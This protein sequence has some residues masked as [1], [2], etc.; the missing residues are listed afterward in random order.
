MNSPRGVVVSHKPKCMRVLTVMYASRS[1]NIYLQGN[2]HGKIRTKAK[3]KRALQTG[4]TGKDTYR[5]MS[6]VQFR[7][8]NIN[9]QRQQ[10][11]L[12]YKDGNEQWKSKIGTAKSNA[13]G[14]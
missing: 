8:N 9:S 6:Q 5:A 1:F 12:L 14:E 10:G 2:V 3:L 7:I 11:Q 13:E 4:W